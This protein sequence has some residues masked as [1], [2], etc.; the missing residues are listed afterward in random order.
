MSKTATDDV[1]DLDFEPMRDAVQ[2]GL[3]AWNATTCPVDEMFNRLL[4]VQQKQLELEQ[5]GI[6][7][8]P[9]LAINEMLLDSVALL[10]DQNELLGIILEQRSFEKA[11]IR[12]VANKIN[13]S[14]D[15]TN[16]RQADAISQLTELIIQQEK[17]LRE[18]SV[19]DAEATL[20]PSEYTQLFGLTDAMDALTNRLLEWDDLWLAAIVGIGGI[21]KTALADAVV[22]RLIRRLRFAHY[23]WIRVD[24]TLS[25]RDGGAEGRSF[26]NFVNQL[27]RALF[28]DAQGGL[29]PQTKRKQ[30]RNRLKESSHLIVVD[31]LENS[32]ETGTLIA[33]LSDWANPSKFLLTTRTQPGGQVG[34][35]LQLLSE[36]SVRDSA[37]LL[38]YHAREI[39]LTDL[40]AATDDELQTITMHTGGNP[41]AI[42]LVVNLVRVMPLPEILAGLLDVNHDD[43]ANLYRRIYRQTWFTL[44]EAA[45]LLLQAM[46]L[47]GQEGGTVAQL[48]AISGLSEDVIWMAISELVRRSLLETRGTIWERRYGIHR[49][50]ES[51]LNNDINGWDDDEDDLF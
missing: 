20:P 16:R 15:Q 42:K 1:F 31:N 27:H 50:T 44:S 29:L 18:A 25:L 17:Q 11:T 39:G 3:K 14:V 33:H 34:I 46:P 7:V 22:R 8:L 26:D 2:Q 51:F 41:L 13:L 32:A 23:A 12:M 6:V 40:A 5:R 48:Q 30:V 37:D 47:I 9:R 28:P 10:K 36:L 43:I 35:H 49:L 21:G 19:K 45:R 24:P 4:L 38:R